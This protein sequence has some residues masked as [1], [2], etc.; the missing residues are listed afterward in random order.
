MARR[1]IVVAMMMHET[2]TFSP[3]PTPLAS[4][5]PLAGG[6]AIEEF[7]DTNTQLGGFLGSRGVPNK[8]TAE[9]RAWAPELI[10]DPAYGESLRRFGVVG[11]ALSVA[12]T[13]KR[14][15]SL[16]SIVL[17]SAET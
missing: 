10:A 13:S 5:R 4:F 3:V 8:R 16:R 6:A 17:I 15:P 1:K 2:N 11:K 9:M 7:R 14:P 12:C